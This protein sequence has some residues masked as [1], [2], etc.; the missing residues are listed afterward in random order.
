SRIGGGTLPDPETQAEGSCTPCTL[1]I[2]PPQNLT[3]TDECRRTLELLEREQ[4]QRVAHDYRDSLL[5]RAASNCSLQAANGQGVGRQSEIGLCFSSA[6][7]K[8]EQVS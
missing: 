1:L 8:P 7:R 6:G 2:L 5:A 3:G 4:A